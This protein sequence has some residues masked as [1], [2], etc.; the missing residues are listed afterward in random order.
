MENIKSNQKG[1][2]LIALVITII[3]LLILAGVAISM[4]SGENGILKQAGKAKTET[5]KSAIEEAIQ[6]GVLESLTDVNHSIDD[7]GELKTN[8]A[9]QLGIS[10]DKVSVVPIDSGY[11]VTVNDVIKVIT[12]DGTVRE[13]NDIEKLQVSE[14]TIK[15]DN[16]TLTDAKGHTIT[17]PVNFNISSESPT[18]VTKGMIIEDSQ[19]N[20]YVWIPVFTKQQ[21]SWGADFSA[22]KT[23]TEGSEAYYTAIKTALK[24][25]TNTYSNSSASDE[26]YGNSS[27]GKYGYN[28]NG[29]L[30]YYTNG[31]MTKTQY[32]TLY[33]N[34]L[35]S[36]YKNGGFYIGRYEMGIDIADSTANATNIYRTNFEEYVST[37]TNSKNTAPSIEGMLTPI[38]KKN[39]VAYSN[40][41][42][43][44]AQML[45]SEIGKQ[46]DYSKVTTSIFF[47]VQ[48]DAVCVFIEK[49][50]T[51]NK[52]GADWLI[53][54]QYTCKW[55]NYKNS[56][57]VMDRGYYRT[58]G[59][60]K[61]FE[62]K[63]NENES[64]LCTTGASDQNSSLN[65][66]DF[67][68]NL[69]EWTLE[70]YNNA[71]SPGIFRGHVY[72]LPNYTPAGRTTSTTYGTWYKNEI[73]ARCTLIL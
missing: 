17:I 47:G 11:K 5:E 67:S 9:K 54:G 28:E 64:W 24:E 52:Y 33:H 73:S 63:T 32:D 55:G 21:Y 1:I 35:N 34:M 38:S 43:Q 30:K 40:I 70:K 19:K 7:E 48:W 39:A 60:W 59:T 3:V 20:Q 18:L 41:T 31:N 2:T 57:Y 10:E 15:E 14:E 45:A 50:D 62:T 72:T 51:K 6:L 42:Q 29:S 16:L 49:F 66:Y 61:D 13:E 71:N 36:V 65:I 22:V 25:Y 56:T 23:Q 4:L 37:E 27:Y 68:G 8:I 53:K 69:G 26:W 44:Q 12:E 46:S 58:S